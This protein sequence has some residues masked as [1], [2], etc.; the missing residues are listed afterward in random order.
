[1]YQVFFDRENMLSSALTEAYEKPTAVNVPCLVAMIPFTLLRPLAWANSYAETH[2]LFQHPNH[3][4]DPHTEALLAEACHIGPHGLHTVA[5]LLT[6]VYHVLC[7]PHAPPADDVLSELRVLSR[8]L[9]G[10]LKHF[11]YTVDR[12]LYDPPGPFRVFA[13]AYYEA[14]QA[15]CLRVSVESSLQFIGNL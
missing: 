7:N 5:E 14:R 3:T 15:D 1:M 12:R 10:L 4:L 2:N 6:K 9:L 11:R 13:Q 8:S